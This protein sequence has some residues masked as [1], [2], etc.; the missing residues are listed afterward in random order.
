MPDEDTHVLRAYRFCLDPTQ[1]QL[2]SLAQHVGA[3]RWAF[4]HALA[5][6]MEV[7][8]S[9]R[10]HVQAL[11]DEG[12]DEQVARKQVDIKIPT[13]FTMKNAWIAIR[14]DEKTGEDGVSPWWRHVSSYAFS[15]AF[16][17]AD[18]AFKN[19]MDSLT[20]K[21]KGRKMGYPKFKKKGRS[22]DSVR[23]YHD[24]KKPTIR[25]DG[26]RRLLIPRIGS[27]R[28]HASTK[29]LVRALRDQ[30]RIQSVTLSRGGS[31]WYAAVLVQEPARR[32]LRP[33]TRAQRAQGAVGVDLG[34]LSLATLSTGEQIANPRF[35]RQGTRRLRK[36]QRRLS[37]TQRGSARRQRAVRQV[38]RLH[39]QVAEQR[40]AF[41]HG[42]TKR[43][44]TGYVRIA[45]EDLNVTGMSASAAGTVDNPGRRVRQKSGLNRSIL[46]AAFGEFRRQL[47]YKTQWY[48]SSVTVV[49]RFFPSSKACSRCGSVKATLSL[50]DRIYTCDHCGL[51]LN[52]DVNAARNLVAW[53][54]DQLVASGGEETLNARGEGVSLSRKRKQSSVKREDHR[55]MATTRK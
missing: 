44:A 8:Q 32:V 14:G 2:V 15:S 23:I 27:V 10:E 45:I 9:W 22:R 13:A 3:S 26:Y 35:T 34:L 48:G 37:R 5:V 51:V 25:P 29:R 16:S 46:D 18:A 47:G 33:A 30:A 12:L 21:R 1:D 20:G 43:L 24:V 19:W 36:A 53:A 41:L 50:R 39:H 52:R 7:H 28:V 55:K 11:V 31:R 49:D 38:G 42:V 40:A 6:K 17:D 4:N 54:A